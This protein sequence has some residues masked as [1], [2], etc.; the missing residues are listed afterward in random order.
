MSE[1]QFL[2]TTSKCLVCDGNS[3]RSHSAMFAPFIAKRIWGREPFP[4]KI[5]KCRRCKFS[6]AD[7]RFE[8]AEENRL[9]ADYRGMEY[10]SMRQ[11]C[12]PWYT[13]QFNA[14]LSTGMMEKRRAPIS[15]IF[16]DHLPCDVK[17]VLDFGGDRGDLFAGLVPGASTYVYDISGIAAAP[18]VTALSSL[19][20]C[21]EKQF[22]L[23][24]CSNV[25][26]HVAYPRKL[27]TDI[28]RIARHRTLVYVEVPSETPFGLRNYAKRSAQ[29]L[30][31]LA[32]RRK[33]AFSLLPF[34]FLHQVHEHVNFFSLD[35]LK[36]LMEVEGF[37]VLAAG[38]YS[39][40]GYSFGP[41]RIAA[42]Q[43]AW[44]LSSKWTRAAK[45]DN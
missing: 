11:S 42:G 35:P 36:R 32:K 3:L 14:R 24:G 9:Y 30:I 16:R 33:I 27:L 20:H 39:S 43:M 41:Y 1:I 44:T 38:T 12:E 26:E 19:D 28:K 31:L 22:D 2:L 15:N 45:D 25:L 29:E 23:I 34:G 8:Q 6:F 37:Y 13:P 4:I 7:T 18:G 17:S 10:Q 40:E 21:A 5:N